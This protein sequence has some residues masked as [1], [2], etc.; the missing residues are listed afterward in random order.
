MQEVYSTFTLR[1]PQE[2]LEYLFH[3]TSDLNATSA[4]RLA[5]KMHLLY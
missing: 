4:N 2:K 5:M 3:L 1:R